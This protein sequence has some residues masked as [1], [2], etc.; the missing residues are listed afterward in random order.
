LALVDQ[1]A[2]VEEI[3]RAEQTANSLASIR[4]HPPILRVLALG[5]VTIV[6][7][8]ISGPLIRLQR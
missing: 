7:S 6:V 2:R 8:T 1:P 3:R 4:T 5:H